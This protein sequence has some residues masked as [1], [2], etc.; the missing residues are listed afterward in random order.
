[1]VK[2]RFVKS[3][4]MKKIIL[5]AT[6]IISLSAFAKRHHSCNCPPKV[7]GSCGVPFTEYLRHGGC[8]KNCWKAYYNDSAVYVSTVYVQDGIPVL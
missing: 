5:L 6:L 7:L 4:F 1:M 8:G 3:I 2:C